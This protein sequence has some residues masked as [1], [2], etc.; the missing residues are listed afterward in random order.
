MLL[1]ALTVLAVAPPAAPPAIDLEEVLRRSRPAL[2]RLAAKAELATAA[3]EL[4]RSRGGLLAGPSITAAAGPRR[5]PEGDDE[6]LALDLDLPLAGDGSERRAAIDAF[7]VA[8]LDLL[9]AARVEADL[10]LRLAYVEQPREA[11]DARATPGATS[12]RSRAGA[13]S[14]PRACSEGQKAPYETRSSRPRSRPPRLGLAEARARV[15]VRSTNSS[16]ISPWSARSFCRS[17]RR[18]R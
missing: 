10:A 6:D 9:A 4:A 2:E 17:R 14:P 18:S 16:P 7:E 5:S 1:T 11:R 15:R 13:R 8:R 12:R 3:R